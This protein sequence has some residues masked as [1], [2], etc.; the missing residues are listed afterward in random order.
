MPIKKLLWIVI[1]L[2]VGG[3]AFFQQQQHPKQPLAPTA[4]QA[5]VSP[6][7]DA[8]IAQAFANQK[9]NLQVSGEGIVAKVLPD[10]KQG[11]RHQKFILKLAN[12][13]SLLVAHNVDLAPRVANL[14]AGDAVQFYGEYEWSHK[15]GVIHW[16][17]HDPRGQHAA[18]W[19]QHQGQRYQ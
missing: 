12:G 18:G 9:S 13:Q 7:S 8:I 4:V 2:A 15:G 11:T 3:Y 16:T 5:Q 17:H 10:D 19:L 6:K 14:R 1:A